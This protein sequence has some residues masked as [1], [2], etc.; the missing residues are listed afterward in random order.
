MYHRTT[1]VPNQLTTAGSPLVTN[2]YSTERRKQPP[3]FYH[4]FLLC[5]A[6][7]HSECS[8]RQCLELSHKKSPTFP[9]LQTHLQQLSTFKM[10]VHSHSAWVRS[11]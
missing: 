7:P 1:R 9:T 3:L 11:S 8:S 6:N 10:A 5:N 2:D 4:S